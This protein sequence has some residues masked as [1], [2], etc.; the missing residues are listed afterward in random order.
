LLT[1]S[2]PSNPIL[3]LAAR[4]VSVALFCCLAAFP[5]SKPED[6]CSIEGTVVNAVTGEPVKKVR[7]FL[8]P[9]SGTP[10]ATTTDSAGHFL[11]DE[12]DAGRYSLT[13]SRSGF[14][15]QSYSPHGGTREHG[16]ILEL[17]SGQDL[18][19][20]VFK[21]VPNAVINGRILDEDGD[22]LSNISVA[23]WRLAYSGGKR[24]FW[25]GGGAETNELGEF[26]LVVEWARK[27]LIRVTPPPL[28]RYQA[29]EE[30]PVAAARAKARAAVERY[31]PTFYPNA[32]NPD[33]ASILDVPA[34]ALIS[35]I[36][37]T[38]V[39]TRTAQIKGHVT[40]PAD[41]P[42]QTN[43]ELDAGNWSI[44]F[45]A[46]LQ[47][48]FQ[49]NDIPPGPYS[50]EA[51]C[52]VKEKS[53]AAR[54]A[55][56][57][58]DENIEGI[59]LTLQPIPGIHGRVIL[60]DNLK[61]VKP[62]LAIHS[63]YTP[64]ML[65]LKNDLTFNLD[66]L[67]LGSYDFRTK[68]SPEN[69]YIK[70]VHMGDRDITDAGL[71]LAPGVPPEPLTIVL[72]PNAGIIEGSVKNAKDE[73]APDALITLIPDV[74]ALRRY[75]TAT[76]DQNGH[77]TIKGVIPGDYKIYAWEEMEEDAYED[78]DFMK[79][80]E[81]DGQALSIKESGHETVQLKLIPAAAAPA[82]LEVVR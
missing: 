60:D 46:D 39:R 77:F 22:P 27:C 79:P 2:L 7:L 81:A 63:I 13:A 56:E 72:S 40:R 47:G 23:C 65:D 73:P 26:Q 34:G 49:M 64:V 52:I 53:Y 4:R 14:P 1:A 35:G 71:D 15:D 20:I 78:P 29:L 62:Q 36:N 6:K 24:Q 25:D 17:A 21:L 48:R 11:I 44:G 19:E 74:A 58:R 43:V 59:E 57:V 45:A 9:R 31:V 67:H 33:R 42:G 75:K 51:R 82:A 41:C 10:Y 30:R 3:R 50:L 38:L 18:K 80:H 61:G 55:I 28:E 32:I 37:I 8:Q 76:T 5:Q 16:S 54:L 68:D 69:V 66:L 12:V 70:S